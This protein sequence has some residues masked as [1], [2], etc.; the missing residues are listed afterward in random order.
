MYEE[1]VFISVSKNKIKGLK[2]ADIA[3]LCLLSIT[4]IFG[5]KIIFIILGCQVTYSQS[6]SLAL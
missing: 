6:P 2:V 5:K 4:D 1:E 3:H